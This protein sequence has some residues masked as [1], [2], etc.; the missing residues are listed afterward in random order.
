[1]T[2]DN[3]VLRT[4][5]S[6][7][8]CHHNADLC[9]QYHLP[10]TQLPRSVKQVWYADDASAC[11]RLARLRDWWDGLVKLVPDLG[12]YPNPPSIPTWLLLQQE[13]LIQASDVF[14]CTDVHIKTDGRP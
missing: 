2:R 9:L 8:R 4:R 5:H 14:D 1:M 12:F 7:G 10:Y 13:H 11:V 6:T 3:T